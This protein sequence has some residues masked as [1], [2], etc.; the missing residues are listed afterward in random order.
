MN[1][2]ERTSGTERR[3][4][5]PN[6]TEREATLR[7]FRDESP[8]AEISQPLFQST[9]VRNR[10]RAN[11]LDSTATTNETTQRA[12]Q[13][14]NNTGNTSGAADPFVN[15]YVKGRVVT[16]PQNRTLDNSLDRIPSRQ[17]TR[18]DDLSLLNDT[19]V[20]EVEPPRSRYG[21]VY[22]PVNRFV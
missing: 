19:S 12:G 8:P 11:L 20:P 4:P 16:R 14:L 13:P 6:T 10:T 7:S 15:V 1:R 5:G 9:P 21:R 18:V 2:T 3:V 17:S 22:Q